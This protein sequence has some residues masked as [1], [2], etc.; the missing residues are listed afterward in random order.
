MRLEARV[1][2][3]ALKVDVLELLLKEEKVNFTKLNID[4]ILSFEL[5]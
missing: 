3:D 2:P 4:E 5:L 1:L